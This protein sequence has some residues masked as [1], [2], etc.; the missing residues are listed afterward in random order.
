MSINDVVGENDGE[1]FVK[2]AIDAVD[3]DSI[4][5]RA[6]G[7]LLALVTK[8]EIIIPRPTRGMGFLLPI[9]LAKSPMQIERRERYDH[10]WSPEML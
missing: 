4:F 8:K 9:M 10:E 5:L 3:I 6:E 7:D 1:I 2:D